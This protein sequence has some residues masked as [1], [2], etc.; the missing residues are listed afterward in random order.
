MQVE[1]FFFSL[2]HESLLNLH[3]YLLLKYLLLTVFH[4]RLLRLF[5]RTASFV[6][7]IDHLY[8]KLVNLNFKLLRNHYAGFSLFNHELV[9]LLELLLLLLIDTAH[10]LNFLHCCAIHVFNLLLNQ[11]FFRHFLLRL[12]VTLLQLI[13]QL[14]VLRV[15]FLL[16]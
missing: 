6:A 16:V 1:T 15:K 7:F 10:L 5:R 3:H 11:S 13:H 9:L 4:L 8:S 2:L 14:L 12:L